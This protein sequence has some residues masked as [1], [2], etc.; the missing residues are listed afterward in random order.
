MTY[1]LRLVIGLLGFSLLGMVISGQ[2]IYSRL[3]YFWTLL[4][5]VNWVWSRFSLRGIDIKRIPNLK[6]GEIGQ[7]FIERFELQNSL[8]F[9]RLWL[10]MKDHS[11]LPG[12][13]GS[14]VF[15]MVGDNRGRSYLGRTRLV[16]RG[17][18]K[19]GP[20][21]IIGGDPFGFFPVSRQ[22]PSTDNLLVFPMLVEIERFPGPP[23]LLPGGESLRRRTH[24]ITPNASNI[25]EY[26][27]GDSL[28]RIHWKSSA[29]RDK[30]MVKEFELDP[31]AEIWIFV[32]GHKEVQARMP[33][34]PNTNVD[35]VFSQRVISYELPPETEEYTATI[36]ASIARYFIQNGRSVGLA[37]NDINNEVLS[38]DKTGRQF[39]KILE[40]MAMLEFEGKMPFPAMVTN[41]CRHLPRG[42]TVIL[43]TPSVAE[44]ITLAVDQITRLGLR[45]IVVLIDAESFGG[46]PGTEK[47]AKEISYFGVPVSVISYQDDIGVRLSRMG[48]QN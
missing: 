19:L 20:T 47:L 11:P 42:S 6:R 43:I 1:S 34:T 36:A 4:I 10:E 23:G 27:A 45:P 31:M 5:A 13:P 39:D 35:G 3:S 21:S 15:V 37:V 14:R 44:D 33:H 16:K 30:L 28:S 48:P 9:P 17:A 26:A 24:Q 18:F 22:F 29:R 8:R 12:S 25:R 40:A 46:Q 32:D 38:P 2:P 41:Q 7:V